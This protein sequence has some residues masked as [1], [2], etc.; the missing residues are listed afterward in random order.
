MKFL[1]AVAFLKEFSIC[2]GLFSVE[3]LAGSGLSPMSLRLQL[4][5]TLGNESV[6]SLSITGGEYFIVFNTRYIGFVPFLL[7]RVLITYLQFNKIWPRNQ[8]EKSEIC[9]NFVIQMLHRHALVWG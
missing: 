6:P 5:P 9:L 2:P 3:E 7:H 8:H 4:F 1:F